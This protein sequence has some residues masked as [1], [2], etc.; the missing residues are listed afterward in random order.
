MHS[1]VIQA[2]AGV[3]ARPARGSWGRFWGILALA[4]LTAFSAHAQ[5]DVS[6]TV[7]HQS[8]LQFEGILVTV[9]VWNK[10]DQFL[11]LGDSAQDDA[12]I[13]LNVR[14]ARN[15]ELEPSDDE[16][17]MPSVMISPGGK[18][19]VIVDVSMRFPMATEGRYM[20]S[21]VLTRG[22]VTRESKSS[23]VD[24]VP[25][26]ELGSQSLA[27]PG[28]APR[29]YRYSMRYWSRGGAEYMFLRVDELATGVNYGVFKLGKLVRVTKPTLTVSAA[30]D[31]RVIHQSGPLAYTHSLLRASKDGVEYVSQSLHLKNGDPYPAVAAE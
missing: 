7:P 6:L 18:R 3:G 5:V 1:K 19:E 4:G 14:N 2:K 10:T 20:I 27:V 28:D 11:K 12:S 16:C 23:L 9:T 17:V 15:E 24:V 22:D 21:A 26:L 8:Y 13:R 25:G 31:V 30:G 29:S